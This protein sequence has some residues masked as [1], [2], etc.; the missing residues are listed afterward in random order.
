MGTE[1]TDRIPRLELSLAVTACGVGV[2]I[3][4]A[5]DYLDLVPLT[6]EPA[7]IA[8]CGGFFAGLLLRWQCAREGTIPDDGPHRVRFLRNWVLMGAAVGALVCFLVPITLPHYL[9]PSVLDGILMGGLAAAFVFPGCQWLLQQAR[10]CVRARL[11]S[12]ISAADRRAIWGVTAVV[13]GVASLAGMLRWT[14]RLPRLSPVAPAMVAAAGFVIALSVV[15]ADWQARARLRRLSSGRDALE[16]LVV[17]ASEDCVAETDLG[18]GEG[19]LG[20]NEA[21]ASYRAERRRIPL[22]RGSFSE[23]AEMIDHALKKSTHRLGFVA[24]TAAAHA[25][26]FSF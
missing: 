4:A 9:P 1:A 14:S 5:S 25:L 11:G 18:V 10:V 2:V 13:L 12:L 24:L 15:L 17:T 21:G 22:V 23:A 26:A 3:A 7:A 16:P 8:S 6:W 19:V 20:H